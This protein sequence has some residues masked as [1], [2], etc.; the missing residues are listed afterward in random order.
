T[1]IPSID[2][3]PNPSSDA[4]RFPIALPF[5]QV[6]NEIAVLKRVSSGHHNIVTLHD[7]FEV[8]PLSTFSYHPLSAPFQKHARWPYIPKKG[9]NKL[10]L[11]NPLTTKKSPLL[12]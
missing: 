3:K 9:L 11:S 6:R 10:S 4:Y 2:F 8:S 1:D 5:H 7:Y 12:I